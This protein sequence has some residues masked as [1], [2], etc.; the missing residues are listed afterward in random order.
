MLIP[1]GVFFVAGNNVSGLWAKAGIFAPLIL[2]AGGHVVMHRMM[3]KSCHGGGVEDPKL[4]PAPVP[5]VD[6]LPEFENRMGSQGGRSTSLE[7]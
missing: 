7:S 5:V 3:G 2:C 4:L 1:V 6:H